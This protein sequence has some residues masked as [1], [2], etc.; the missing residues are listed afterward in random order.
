MTGW[1]DVGNETENSTLLDCSGPGSSG[2]YDCGLNNVGEWTSPNVSACTSSF[3]ASWQP[4][5]MARCKAC[6]S[7]WLRDKFNF[8]GLSGAC[9]TQRI[10]VLKKGSSVHWHWRRPVDS[11]KAENSKDA[12]C[13][14]NKWQA[15]GN[16]RDRPAG[17]WGVGLWK[18]DSKPE[19][20]GGLWQ[21]AST[22]TASRNVSGMS[23]FSNDLKK[24]TLLTNFFQANATTKGWIT[25]TPTEVGLTYWTQRIAFQR[26]YNQSS[27]PNPSPVQVYCPCCR[28]PIAHGAE[29]SVQCL[30]GY[31]LYPH[32][33]FNSSSAKCYEGEWYKPTCAAS[34]CS[35]SSTPVQAVNVLLSAALSNADLVKVANNCSAVPSGA[36]CSLFCNTG[37][38][39]SGDIQC[40]VSA[41]QQP[42]AALP[43][44]GQSLQAAAVWSS[45]LPTCQPNPCNSVDGITSL[46]PKATMSHCVGTPHGQFCVL[47]CLNDT[48]ARQ[49]WSPSKWNGN[50]FILDNTASVQC[51]AG[52]WLLNP[53]NLSISCQPSNC[54]MKP[55]MKR[56]TVS[57]TYEVIDL[58]E[59]QGKAHNSE[60]PCMPSCT[61]GDLRPVSF[62]CS[63]G[64]YPL[65]SDGIISAICANSATK[66]CVQAPSVLNGVAPCNIWE[67]NAFC[68]VT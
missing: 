65:G 12:P 31:T 21:C 60:F 40:V 53:S 57:N 62:N 2:N 68:N 48:G 43:T 3:K 44:D 38:S 1:L 23:P 19:Y 8:D 34:V 7:F 55:K 47:K 18:M 63:F 42:G 16:D 10:H 56:Q 45:T 6:A 20:S 27:N 59:C 5:K 33:K 50:A 37:Y 22:L 61:L 9:K 64:Y 39:A 51:Q 30:D 46:I 24:F 49:S 36:S 54:Q 52:L 4:E 17:L 29:C 26:D 11:G 35:Y 66:S 25:W 58:D 14:V 28:P 32:S 41:V 13:R 67:A 15:N